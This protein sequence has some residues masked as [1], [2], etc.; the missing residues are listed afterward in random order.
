MVRLRLPCLAIFAPGRRGQQGNSGGDVEGAAG[1]A[2]GAAGVDECRPFR[3]RERQRDSS[4]AHGIDETGQLVRGHVARCESGQKC[5]D[6]G[7][8]QCMLGVFQN[9]LHHGAGL[10]AAQSRLLLRHTAQNFG[11]KCHRSNPGK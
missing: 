3:V 2:A 8:R 9:G 7:I 6:F 11:L 4:G 5:G 10:L 1:I